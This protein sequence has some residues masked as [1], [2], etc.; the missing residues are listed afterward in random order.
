MNEKDEE[1]RCSLRGRFQKEF[2]LKRG[3]L[4]AVDIVAV[5]DQVLYEMNNDGSGVI[6]KILPRRNYISRKAP[7]IKGAST[8]GERL[9]QIVAANIDNLVIVSS[10]QLPK[11]NNRLID[12][13]IVIGESSH[14]KPIIVINKTDLDTSEDFKTL[15]QLYQ[16]IGYEVLATSIITKNGLEELRETMKNRINLMWGQS[17]VGK[18]S[19][20]NEIYTSLNFKIGTIS[21]S[22]SKGK[23]TTVTSVLRKV[24][25]GTFIIDTPGIREIDPYGVR[26]EDLGHYFVEFKPFQDNCRFNT[27][28]HDHEPGCAIIEAVENE[29]IDKLRYQSYLNMLATVEDDMNF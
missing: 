19:L 16:G 18:S 29:L 4:F 17:G 28:T 6:E 22:T 5:G 11:L 12:R 10:C 8:R 9:E 21:D 24:D 1:V 13:L 14:I 27:C 3:K 26:K 2:A 23:H 15:I 7:K 20:L 25:V